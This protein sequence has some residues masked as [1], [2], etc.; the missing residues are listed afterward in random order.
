MKTCKKCDAVQQQALHRVLT[1]M[2][3]SNL[4]KTTKIS[5][6]GLQ[7]HY[8]HV[9]K[10]N[11]WLLRRIGT[12]PHRRDVYSLYAS[13]RAIAR[14]GD[15]PKWGPIA[16]HDRSMERFREKTW[17]LE[18]ALRMK[19]LYGLQLLRTVQKVLYRCITKNGFKPNTHSLEDMRKG[20]VLRRDIF[21]QQYARLGVSVNKNVAW[22]DAA[23]PRS[24]SWEGDMHTSEYKK[25][26]SVMAQ[27]DSDVLI[28][29]DMVRYWRKIIMNAHAEPR[30]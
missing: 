29:K 14:W 15:A 13:M 30:T 19:R 23:G 10:K 12:V 17:D 1:W 24:R 22:R 25:R 21:G 16:M 26:L 18:D 20:R 28:S 11:T 7:R 3:F 4:S 2:C 27:V 8:E 5:F 9:L 6:A